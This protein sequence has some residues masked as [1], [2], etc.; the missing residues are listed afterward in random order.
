M[1]MDQQPTPPS[2]DATFAEFTGALP[3]FVPSLEEG[4]QCIE[5]LAA[6]VRDKLTDPD[7]VIA[8][9]TG[10]LAE[11]LFDVVVMCSKERRN[12]ALRLLRTPYEKF[13]YA[14][15]ISRHPETANDFRV[16]DGIQSPRLM[17]S[18]DH[19]GRTMNEAGMAGLAAISKQA[20]ERFKRRSWTTVTTKQ[21]AKAAG[22]DK[23]YFFAYLYSTYLIHPTFLGI[24]TQRDN[25]FSCYMPTIL[26]VVHTLT[27]VTLKLQGLCFKKTTTVTGRTADVM[28]RLDGFLEIVQR[29]A[30][31]PPT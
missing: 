5:D 9:L 19:Y 12:G 17:A 13:L 14:S 10:S 31:N 11:D 18:M 29:S 27:L 15:H 6:E 8:M 3:D 26:G 24:S 16:Y 22:L 25:S 4:F 1:K 28:M 23:I 2:P 30:R 20:E 21:M 7:A